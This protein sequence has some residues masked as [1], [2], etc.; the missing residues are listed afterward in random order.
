MIFSRANI[1]RLSSPSKHSE[2]AHTWA[3][4]AAALL[5]HH[6]PRGAYAGPALPTFAANN[7]D[8]KGA[9]C[10]PMRACFPRHAPVSQINDMRLAG[11]GKLQNLR[12]WH[13]MEHR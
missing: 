11:R 13:L 4:R 9:N 5:S 1:F 10:L 6:G 8:R 3:T 7:Q 12:R 2:V